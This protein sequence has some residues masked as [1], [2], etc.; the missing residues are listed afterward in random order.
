MAVKNAA[1]APMAIGY[2]SIVPPC[3]SKSSNI[4]VPTPSVI[5]IASK[6]ENRA[7]S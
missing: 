7:A 4:F 3:S 1:V 6:K 2:Q 5:G